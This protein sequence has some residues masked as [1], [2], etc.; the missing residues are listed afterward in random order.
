MTLKEWMTQRKM[1]D[2]QM[3]ELIET[4]R[5]AVTMYRNGVRT[6]KP[7]IAKRIFKVTSGD[8]TP[9]DFWS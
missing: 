2:R 9:M 8:V 6:P 5:V 3:A 7:E 4:S 1:S